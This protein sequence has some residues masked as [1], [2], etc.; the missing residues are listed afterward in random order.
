MTTGNSPRLCLLD[1][2]LV[3]ISTDDVSCECRRCRSGVRGRRLENK[4]K[5]GDN[6]INDRAHR[7]LRWLLAG[8]WRLKTRVDRSMEG[9][10]QASSL[11]MKSPRRGSFSAAKALF[12][13]LNFYY[14]FY[15]FKRSI[16]F[17]RPALALYSTH[18]DLLM[19]NNP[20]SLAIVKK[21]KQM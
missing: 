12:L 15:S 13:S 14:F 10:F 21:I 16:N 11:P 8:C 4:K 7:H 1:H 6:S 9:T 20:D 5:S 19:D 2:V 3:L 18:P 17:V